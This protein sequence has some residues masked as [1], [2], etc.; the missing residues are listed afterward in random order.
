LSRG[1]F[2]TG[3]DL[4]SDYHPGASL[5]ALLTALISLTEGLTRGSSVEKVGFW[6]TEADKNFQKARLPG[7]D[8]FSS[9]D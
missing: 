3:P 8:C 4:K 7:C 1:K 5:Y 9:L 6:Q 2:T